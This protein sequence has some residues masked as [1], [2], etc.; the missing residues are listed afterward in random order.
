MRQID[1]AVKI[2]KQGGIVVYPTD[3]AYGL[4]VDATNVE[5]VRKLYKLKGRKFN[6]PIHVIVPSS[7]WLNKIVK[8]DKSSMKLMNAFFPG[9]LTVVLPLKAKSESWKLLSAGTGTLGIRLPD[10]KLAI[11]LVKKFGKPITTTSANLSGKKACYSIEEVKKQFRNNI[12]ASSG[13]PR[14]S[15]QCTGEPD[16]YLD[17][18]KLKRVKPSTIV[19][20]SNNHVKIIRQGPISKTQILKIIF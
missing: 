8:L 20:I 11:G 14:R 9:P 1:K 13:A 10:N 6:K 18:G 15:S 16:F 4:A 5:A 12:A 19:A 7:T 3:T 17:G 2:L